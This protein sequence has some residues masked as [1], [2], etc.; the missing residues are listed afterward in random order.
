VKVGGVTEG[1]ARL[2][3]S[4]T[5]KALLNMNLMLKNGYVNGSIPILAS[6][7]G[8]HPII[9]KALI[10]PLRVVGIN[11]NT[12]NLETILN[13]YKCLYEP[14]PTERLLYLVRSSFSVAT[15]LCSVAKIVRS[16]K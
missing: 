2:K 3:R 14:F 5:E 10:S 4:R 8:I 9:D 7:Q 12:T 16:K 13:T 1:E 11:K 6:I 15:T